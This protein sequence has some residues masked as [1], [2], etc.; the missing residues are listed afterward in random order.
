MRRIFLFSLLLTSTLSYANTNYTHELKSIYKQ[1]YELINANIAINSKLERSIYL[2]VINN[3]NLR[4]RYI[5]RLIEKITKNEDQLEKLDN[6]IRYINQLAAITNS[7]S[8]LNKYH[9]NELKHIYKQQLNLRNK[10]IVIKGRIDK[11]LKFDAIN[12][13][14]SRQRHIARL[15]KNI[16]NNN[17]RLEKL[18]NRL[19]YIHQMINLENSTA[20]L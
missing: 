12:N 5:A 14:N 7:S 10:N 9:K 16:T 4:Q 19:N 3:T 1:Q 18:D 2:D 20:S 15:I 8:N 11:A 13:T 6:R 17:D